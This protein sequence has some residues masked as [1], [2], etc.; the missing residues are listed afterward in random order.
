MS[1]FLQPTHDE[2]HVDRLSCWAKAALFFGEYP[3]GLAVVT[4]AGRDDFQ[5]NLAWMGKKRNTSVVFAIRAILLFTK[6]LNRRIFPL[7]GDV[8]RSPHVDK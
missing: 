7:M 1:E 5:Q 3:F 2:Q 6:D 4:E 8:T